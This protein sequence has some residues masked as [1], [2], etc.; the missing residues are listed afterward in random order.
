MQELIE[1]MAFGLELRE[2]Q[3][4]KMVESLLGEQLAV[5]EKAEFLKALCK[6]GETANEM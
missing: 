4:E 1:S 6:K 5:G 3:V 2:R